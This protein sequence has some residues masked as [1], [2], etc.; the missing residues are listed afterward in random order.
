MNTAKVTASLI[1]NKKIS[2]EEVV[3]KALEY[4]YKTKKDLNAFITIDEDNAIEKARNLDKKNYHC[5][6]GNS[7]VL[8]GM[9]IAIK[10]NI[11][12][13]GIR[14]T[15]ASK[16]LDN[17]VPT[18]SATV[19]KRLERAGLIVIGKTNMDEFGMGSTGE[20][21]YY[22]PVSNPY[23]AEC[24]SGGSSSGSC[25]YVSGKK[26][27]LALG[28]DTGG[29]IRQPASYCGLVGIKPTYST[30]SRNGLIAYAPS[31]DTIGSIASNVS[32]ASALLQ[33]IS[34]YDSLD[35][36]SKNIKE[37]DYMSALTTDI[38]GMKIGIVKEFLSD[39]TDNDIKDKIASVCKLL[40]KKGAIIKECSIGL[41]DEALKAYY[42][43]AC[44]QASSNLARFDGVK[45]GYRA[46]DYNDLHDMYKKTRSECFGMEVKRRIMLGSFV[47]SSGYYDA[48]Y[49]KALKIRRLVNEEYAKLFSEFDAL[50]S[51]C[52]MTL[53]PKKETTK[54]DPLNMYMSD[55]CTVGANLCGNPAISFPC[56]SSTKGK[57]MPIGLQFIGDRF[58]E[59]KII[60][61][62]YT[63]SKELGLED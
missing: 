39:K 28:T 7:S 10:D 29:S 12:T 18:Y 53:A 54:N 32:D 11:C 16:I 13:K 58:C 17:F 15:A 14:T 46:S 49:L 20:N 23:N 33:I 41:S 2:C 5:D 43:I 1:K 55:I 3:R 59:N 9:P 42:I 24:V 51:P 63:Y 26:G 61:L 37:Y 35:S 56:G 31:F 21:S 60:K 8:F 30:V 4:A 19:V 25:A 6:S 57:N 34:G 52:A 22:G 36:T 47:L 62:A 44:A 38:K 48:Y 50:I 40:E 27:L 45:Y